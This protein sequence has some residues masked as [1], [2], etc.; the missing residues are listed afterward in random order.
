MPH[1]VKIIGKREEQEETGA[2]PLGTWGDKHFGLDAKSSGK[3]LKEF[4]KRNKT[5]LVVQWLRPHLPMQG[6]WVW[7][8]IGELPKKKRRNNQIHLLK[9]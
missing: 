5:S 2:R 7:S 3:L 1:G 6:V 4:K 9:H 8:L